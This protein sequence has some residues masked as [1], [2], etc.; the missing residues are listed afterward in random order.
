MKLSNDLNADGFRLKNV[1]DPAS[2]QDALTAMALTPFEVA[3]GK[4]V[5]VPTGRQML[6][7]MPVSFDGSG[8]IALDG[9]MVEVH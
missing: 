6:F 4:T 3:D 1:A 9:A 8:S 5:R 2:D 7:A